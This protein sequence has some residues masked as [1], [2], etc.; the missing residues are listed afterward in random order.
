MIVRWRT[1]RKAASREDSA[2]RLN[3]LLPKPALSLARVEFLKVEFLAHNFLIFAFIAFQESRE[4][5]DYFVPLEMVHCR[6]RFVR[7]SSCAPG[8]AIRSRGFKYKLLHKADP[9]LSRCR[10]S[11]RLGR[12]GEGGPCAQGVPKG[13]ADIPRFASL[14]DRFC[15]WMVAYDDTFDTPE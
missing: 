4:V 5:T 15:V 11:R 1:V 3:P 8:C 9:S 14:Q 7:L 6:V 2:G 13:G 12:G 10:P